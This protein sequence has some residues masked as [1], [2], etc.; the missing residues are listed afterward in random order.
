MTSLD[1]PELSLFHIL[2]PQHRDSHHSLTILSQLSQDKAAILAI[3]SAA[4]ND[5]SL[6]KRFKEWYEQLPES[7]DDYVAQLKAQLPTQKRRSKNDGFYTGKILNI[8][9]CKQQRI[10]L[11]DIID[12]CEAIQAYKLTLL[13]MQSSSTSQQVSNL[14]N[15]IPSPP[16]PP[17][18][19]LYVGGLGQDILESEI[20][21]GF[22]NFLGIKNIF[23][24]PNKTNPHLKAGYCFIEFTNYLS[25]AGALQGPVFIRGRAVNVQ[26]PKDSEI[27]VNNWL[28][29]R[30]EYEERYGV[31]T[32]LTEVSNNNLQNMSHNNPQAIPPQ[33]PTIPSTSLQD[34]PT[35]SLPASNI[36]GNILCIANMFTEEDKG[37]IP[38]EELKDEITIQCD[39]FGTILDIL[40]RFDKEITAKNIAGVENKYYPVFVT[41]NNSVSVQDAI[42]GIG[43]LTFDG[44]RLYAYATDR[45]GV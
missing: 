44:R 11:R 39:K 29:D 21:S 20:E 8:L 1:S 42:K 45:T 2:S 24:P 34:I 31:P 37:E 43:G 15:S 32:I 12:R 40:V 14:T 38:L 27:P 6:L 13:T 35:N 23:L 41:Y 22:K 7:G 18:F 4:N 33:T 17:A 36:N 25:F 10:V 26:M 16:P 30:K 3:V 28:K 19:R 5:P 9:Y